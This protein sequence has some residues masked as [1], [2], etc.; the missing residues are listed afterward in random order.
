MTVKESSST[1]KNINGNIIST[2]K[3]LQ[4]ENFLLGALNIKSLNVLDG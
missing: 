2:E 4:I 1:L 3:T